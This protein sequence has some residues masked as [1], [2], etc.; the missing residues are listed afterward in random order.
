MYSTVSGIDLRITRGSKA[1]GDLRLESLTVEGWRPVE[2]A[3]AFYT[4][5]FFTENEDY[6]RQFRPFWKQNGQRYFL[7]E[8]VAAVRDGWEPTA[9]RIERQR[10]EW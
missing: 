2:M 5:D 1:P 10:R 3:L 4:V 7:N 6:L 8:C 9:A